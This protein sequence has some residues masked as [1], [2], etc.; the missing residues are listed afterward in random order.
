MCK[1]VSTAKGKGGL[2]PKSS[3]WISF[4][5]PF[6]R[7]GF[8]QGLNRRALSRACAVVLHASSYITNNISILNLHYWA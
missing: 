3:M 2:L 1:E 4:M 8:C 5:G 6:Y 7:K